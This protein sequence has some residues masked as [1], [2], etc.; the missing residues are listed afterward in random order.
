MKLNKDKRLTVIDEATERLRNRSC[1]FICVAFNEALYE[2]YGIKDG[3]KAL[4]DYFPEMYHLGKQWMEQKK[5]V[6]SESDYEHSKYPLSDGKTPWFAS[7]S[8]RQRL[9]FMAELRHIIETK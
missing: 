2:I 8:Y 3:Y 7:D 6:F 9:S 4:G 1:Q 5:I